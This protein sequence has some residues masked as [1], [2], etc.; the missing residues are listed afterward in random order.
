MPLVTQSDPGTEN[1]GLANGHTV[2]RHF[3][4]P[5]LSGTRQHRYKREKKN[6]MSEIGWS[7]LR[8]RFTPGFENRLEIGVTMGWYDPNVPLE[9]CVALLPVV[10]C[11]RK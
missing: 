2:L 6:I 5:S 9:A 3:H 10:Y 11:D 8:R 1:V 4:D 7:Q